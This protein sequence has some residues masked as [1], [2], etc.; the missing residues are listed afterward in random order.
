MKNTPYPFYFM[1][2]KT[3]TLGCFIFFFS[4]NTCPRCII[5]YRKSVILEF[6]AKM[7][8]SNV[9]HLYCNARLAHSIREPPLYSSKLQTKHIALDLWWA[10]VA[11]LC[12]H[13]SLYLN[14][15]IAKST[16]LRLVLMPNKLR[17]S[18]K[19]AKSHFFYS[20]YHYVIFFF[21][22]LVK[23]S[24]NWLRMIVK[25]SNG[26]CGGLLR[27][28]W[29]FIEGM[30]W[31]WHTYI[32]ITAYLSKLKKGNNAEIIYLLLFFQFMKVI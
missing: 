1:K 5:A 4:S 3:L 30:K 2:S 13:F 14:N 6:T 9:M 20:V 18:N 28:F 21:F 27:I 10:R 15:L 24:K 22:Y 17:K 7:F 16:S 12:L 19:M 29:W 23:K 11:F 32:S 31:F 26:S 25:E 8:L